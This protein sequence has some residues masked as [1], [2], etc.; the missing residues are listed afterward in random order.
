MEK[1][2]NHGLVRESVF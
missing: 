2:Y 1:V